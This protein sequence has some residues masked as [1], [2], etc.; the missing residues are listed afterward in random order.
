MWTVG[1]ANHSQWWQWSWRYKKK[2]NNDA[3]AQSEHTHQNLTRLSSWSQPRYRRSLLHALPS[4]RFEVGRLFQRVFAVRCYL[5]RM[6]QCQKLWRRLFN[7]ECDEIDT[8]KWGSTHFLNHHDLQQ[9]ELCLLDEHTC[10]AQL[11]AERMRWSKYVTLH[12]NN[13]ASQLTRKKSAT[14][15]PEAVQNVTRPMFEW[16]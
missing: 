5:A 9:Q 2:D 10:T 14:I 16:E 15:R 3:N 1:C 11:R 12:Q 7:R 8:Q 4:V 13:N 6:L